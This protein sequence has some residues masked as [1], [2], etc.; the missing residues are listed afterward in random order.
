MEIR[1]KSPNVAEFNKEKDRAKKICRQIRVDT[2]F[3]IE[4]FQFPYGD[5]KR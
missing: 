1:I 4:G 5:G 3:S 2:N